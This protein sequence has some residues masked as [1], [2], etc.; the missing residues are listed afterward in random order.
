MFSFQIWEKNPI[1][2]SFLHNEFIVIQAICSISFEV[3]W[4]KRKFNARKLYDESK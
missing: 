4:L 1:Q 2:M 3:I